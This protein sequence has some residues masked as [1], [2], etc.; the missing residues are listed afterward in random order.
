MRRISRPSSRS[1]TY[2]PGHAPMAS[3]GLT[4]RPSGGSATVSARFIRSSTRGLKRAEA[5]G[6]RSA[7]DS[8]AYFRRSPRFPRIGHRPPP[9]SQSGQQNA[10]GGSDLMD[11]CS[12][13][14]YPVSATSGPRDRSGARSIDRYRRSR[15]LECSP[16]RQL[17]H[18]TLPEEPELPTHIHPLRQTRRN[19]PSIHQL[20]THPRRTQSVNTPWQLEVDR[21]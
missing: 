6:L 3:A 16:A 12:A 14:R 7:A 20:R 13:A 11:Q 8:G 15:S 10:S 1:R 5:P 21:A 4:G 19:V 18:H 9:S 2:S 17:N